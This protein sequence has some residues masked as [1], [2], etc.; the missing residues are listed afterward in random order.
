MRKKKKKKLKKKE[1]CSTR[2]NESTVDYARVSVW[3]Y[4]QFLFPRENSRAK[5]RRE[6]K[7]GEMKLERHVSSL[8][9][10]QQYFSGAHLSRFGCRGKI[11]NEWGVYRVIPQPLNF[12][13]D[14]EAKV[15]ASDE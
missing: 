8:L 10:F 2:W 1:N 14:Q 5:G 7:I 11:L 4:S 3:N 15:D 13:T 6:E 12:A 9:F